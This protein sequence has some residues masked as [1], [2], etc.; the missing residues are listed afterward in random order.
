MEFKK[1]VKKILL[2][3][4][5]ASFLFSSVFSPTNSKANEIEDVSDIPVYTI[6]DDGN[7]ILS[8]TDPNILYAMLQND[9]NN[10]MLRQVPGPDGNAVRLGQPEYSVIHRA[11]DIYNT[12]KLLGT[13]LWTWYGGSLYNVLSGEFMSK[14]GVGAVVSNIADDFVLSIAQSYITNAYTTSYMYKSWSTYYNKDMVYA[15]VA[16]YSDSARSHL[17]KFIQKQLSDSAAAIALK[18]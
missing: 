14:T 4:I 1:S 18:Q 15:C 13:L 17:T 7:L 16:I 8:D 3:T 6:D 11:Q 12:I 2:T 5:C 10:G 9:A